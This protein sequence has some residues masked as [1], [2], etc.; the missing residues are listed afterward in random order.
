[1]VMYRIGAAAMNHETY[2]RYL[3]KWP[4]CSYPG[5][6]CTVEDDFN[7]L[8][9]DLQNFCSDFVSGAGTEFAAFAAEHAVNPDKFKG[10][11]AI[12]RNDR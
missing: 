7:A 5:F 1:M 4:Q 9:R 6:G 8:A 10:F 3:E 12:G 11:S 2:L